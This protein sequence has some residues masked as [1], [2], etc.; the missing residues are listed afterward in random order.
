MATRSRSPLPHSN[1]TKARPKTMQATFWNGK[2]FHMEVRSAPVPKLQ[3]ATDCIVRLTTAAICGSDLHIFHGV[4]GS[5]NLPYGVG[6]EGVGIV[7]EIG[8]GCST[9]KVGDRVIVLAVPDDGH[10]NPNALDVDLEVY[11]NGADFGNLGG[12]QGE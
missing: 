12:L 4:F 11:G 6:H 5:N 9:V 3:E 10:A 8:H 1:G 2:P 7:T